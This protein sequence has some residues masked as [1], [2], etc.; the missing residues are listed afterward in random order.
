MRDNSHTDLFGLVVDLIPGYV[1]WIA[2]DLTYRGVNQA[3]ADAFGFSRDSIVGKPLGGLSDPERDDF[4]RNVR[5]FFQSSLE[6]DSFEV[7]LKIGGEER[8]QLVEAK[9]YQGGSEAIFVG[10][11]ITERKRLE[12]SFLEERQQR[13]ESARLACLG[14]MAASIAHEIK[15]PLGALINFAD[16]AVEC[17][18]N[19]TKI[20][21]LVEKIQRN[22][23]RI[24]KIVKGLQTHARRGD[25]DP[26]APASLKEIIDDTIELCR[27]KYRRTNTR[28]ELGEFP[29]DFRFDCRATQIAQVLL[30]LL[31]NAADAV[32][33]LPERWVRL[34]FRD[35]GDKFDLFITDSGPGIPPEV[36][37]R[38][39][40][41]FFTT[42]S[43]GKGTGLGLSLSR[44][45]S[46]EH[47]GSLTIDAKCSNTR[48]VLT[49]PKRHAPAAA[50][51]AA[52]AK[53]AA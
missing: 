12:A 15:S 6:H 50:A 45:I 4:C 24:T 26:F 28:F 27:D 22:A 7:R 36:A 20:R 30:N 46:T 38:L 13:L 9:K 42:K 35:R 40:Q 8:W 49:L 14:E 52:K 3:V 53:K 5:R 18:D 17:T 23:E 39:M 25:Q 31:K 10:I 2:S 47:K 48:F 41:P 16:L 34:E 33:A 51:S 11:D 21:G 43:V 1:S 37:K 29:Q 19:P 32:E 44:R